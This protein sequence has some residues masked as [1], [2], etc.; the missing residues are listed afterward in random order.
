[1]NRQQRYH[2]PDY[3]LFQQLENETV[4]LNLEDGYYYGL[5]D[6][7]T[8]IW[9][10]LKQGDSLGECLEW[11]LENYEVSPEQAE[12]DLEALIRHMTEKGLIEPAGS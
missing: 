1:M 2:I 7:G 12:K 6:L 4:L 3:V 9:Q 5:D 8:R 10:M 11:I